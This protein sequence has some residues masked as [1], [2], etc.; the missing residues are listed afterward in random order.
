[1]FIKNLTI[2]KNPGE[3]ITKTESGEYHVSLD[4]PDHVATKFYQCCNLLSEELGRPL[5]KSEALMLMIDRVAEEFE[6]EKLKPSE[7]K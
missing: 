3:T 5:S 4:L 7:K 6:A 1:M 2:A